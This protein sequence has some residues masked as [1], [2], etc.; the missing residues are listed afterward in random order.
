[1]VMRGIKC[2][3]TL[4]S[5]DILKDSL[6]GAAAAKADNKDLYRAKPKLQDPDAYN[7]YV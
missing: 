6:R 1:M 7:K 2:P 5:D 3:D 4:H